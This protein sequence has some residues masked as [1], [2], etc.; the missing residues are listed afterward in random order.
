MSNDYRKTK[1]VNFELKVDGSLQVI[2][3]ICLYCHGDIYVSRETVEC[4]FE[5]DEHKAHF[6]EEIADLDLAVIE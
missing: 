4:R 3:N 5:T 1:I 6:L 2:T